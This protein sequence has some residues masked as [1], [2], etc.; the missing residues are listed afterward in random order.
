MRMYLVGALALAGAVWVVGCGDDDSGGGNGGS[1][2]SGGSSGGAG[3]SG[4]ASGGSSGGGTGGASGGSSGSG[5]STGGTGGGACGSV[6]AGSGGSPAADAGTTSVNGKVYEFEQSPVEGGAPKPITGV[7]V[8]QRNTTNC[9]TS[10]ATGSYSLPV[11]AKTED[12]LLFTKT[13]YAKVAVPFFF[14]GLSS[15][16]VTNLPTETLAGL[17]AAAAKIQWPLTD[18]GIVL[19]GTLETIAPDAG[20]AGSYTTGLAGSTLSLSPAAPVGPVYTDDNQFP[21]PSATK[22]GKFGWAGFGELCPGEYVVKAANPGRVCSRTSVWPA[23]SND[24]ART[25]AIAG[26]VTTQAWFVCD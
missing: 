10:D 22:T 11:P 14:S 15:S 20:D 5:G 17:F 18:R 23:S 12:V 25:V 13:G 24:T 2:G 1:A 3:G 8:C 4:G 26:H 9:A 21:A 7:Q 6:D 19:A 16:P